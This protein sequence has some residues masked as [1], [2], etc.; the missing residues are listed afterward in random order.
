MCLKVDVAKYWFET[1][2]SQRLSRGNKGECWQ[3]HLPRKPHGI[4]HHHQAKSSV[5]H[6]NRV[7][8]SQKFLEFFF[9]FF[10]KR[11]IVVV[12]LSLKDSAKC[13]LIA[14]PRWEVKLADG[15]R[16]FECGFCAEKSKVGCLHFISHHSHANDC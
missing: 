8:D 4:R 14:F 1:S 12:V 7:L 9:E 2:L 10:M 6:T 16:L 11:A 5:T 3:D 13:G 15:K